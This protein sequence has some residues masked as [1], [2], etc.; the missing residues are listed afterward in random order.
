MCLF[1]CSQLFYDGHQ[2]MGVQLSTLVQAHP[3]VP[4][5][6]RLTNLVSL[7]LQKEESDPITFPSRPRAGLDLDVPADT[8]E[9]APE[10]AMYETIYVTSHKGNCRVGAFSPDGELCATGSVD[11]SIKVSSLFLH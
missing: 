9:V 5:S 8:T 3:P 7:A 1:G 10:P 6:E 11:T 4:P 2:T